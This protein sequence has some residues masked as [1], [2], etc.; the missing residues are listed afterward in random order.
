MCHCLASI[1]VYAIGKI[2][3]FFHHGQTSLYFIFPYRDFFAG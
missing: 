2:A 1:G 3:T